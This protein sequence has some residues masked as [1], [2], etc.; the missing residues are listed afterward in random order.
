MRLTVGITQLLP[1]WEIVLQQIGVSFEIISLKEPIS[2]DQFSVVIVT[3]KG[4]KNEKDVL[5][6][7]LNSGGSILTEAEVGKWLF[8]I[9]TVPAFVNTIEPTKDPIFNGVLP[10]F[11]QMRLFLK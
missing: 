11:I 10:G 8:N 3:T 7:Y 4:A 9:G 6:H 5:L 1:E 2:A